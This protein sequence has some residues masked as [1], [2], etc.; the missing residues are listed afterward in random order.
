LISTLFVVKT[1]LTRLQSHNAA[2]IASLG[3]WFASWDIL[4]E[5][6]DIK[7]RDSLGSPIAEE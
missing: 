1:P 2:H 7:R 4:P 6:H 3:L 5:K